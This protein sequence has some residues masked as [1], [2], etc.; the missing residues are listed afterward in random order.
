[1][2]S[3]GIPGLARVDV[4]VV[5][6]RS[7]ADPRGDGRV[8][9]DERSAG[10]TDPGLPLSDVDRGAIRIGARTLACITWSTWSRSPDRRGA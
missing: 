2:T 3:G 1:M 9:V 6:R 8:L 7:T 4:L 10:V 5:M